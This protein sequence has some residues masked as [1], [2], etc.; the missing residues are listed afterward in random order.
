MPTRTDPRYRA[1]DTSYAAG[2]RLRAWAGDDL[3]LPMGCWA[4]DDEVAFEAAIRDELVFGLG[5]AEAAIA[6]RVKI[7]PV[8][9]D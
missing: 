5:D 7:V 8:E 2:A 1:H 3:T 9:P 6:A 4:D